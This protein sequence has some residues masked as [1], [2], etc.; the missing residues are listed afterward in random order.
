MTPTTAPIETTPEHFITELREATLRADKYIELSQI[1]I[2]GQPYRP[3]ALQ[4]PAVDCFV[5]DFPE[6]LRH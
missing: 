3:K 5:T 1:H 6:E 2:P 4:R